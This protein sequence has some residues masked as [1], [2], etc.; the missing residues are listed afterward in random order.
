MKQGSGKTAVPLIKKLYGISV[1]YSGFYFLCR[2]FKKLFPDGEAVIL[3]YHRACDNFEE[4]MRHLHENCSVITFA[5]LYGCIRNK[6]KLPENSVIITFDDGYRDN[7]TLAYPALK[8]YR[9]PAT[10]FLATGHIGT[11]E[12]FWWDKVD[13]IIK[14]SKAKKV[15]LS[16]LGTFSLADRAKAAR[17][18]QQKLKKIHERKKNR[19]IAELAEKLNVEIPRQKNLL[20]SWKDVREMG[21]NNISFGAHTVS[22]PILTK[23]SLKQ[24]KCEILNSKEKIE[25]MLGKKVSVFAYPNG[26][27]D[28]MSDGIDYFLKRNGFI[29]S[30]S[31]VYGSNKI[32]QPL[33]RL[34]RVGIQ[35]DDDMRLFRIKLLGL[36][37]TAARIYLSLLR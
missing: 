17:S 15:S 33:F 25:K 7:Y 8:K 23:I 24:A 27:E 18:I 21:R 14:K 2:T 5:D 35:P 28:D 1:Y 10:V 32:R 4:Q 34:R 29:F 6:K 9:H 30:L 20:L 36:G 3:M 22:H 11:E 31:T 26:S 12:L 19:L 37:K 16:G 13:C